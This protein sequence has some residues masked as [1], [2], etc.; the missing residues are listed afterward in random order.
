L[1]KELTK[2]FHSLGG[3]ADVYLK[4]HK[5]DVRYL[6][7]ERDKGP[8]VARRLKG[9]AIYPLRNIL[10]DTAAGADLTSRFKAFITS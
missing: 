10:K 2:I 6:A 3:N 7:L 9:L 4:F 5:T 1:A 8:D